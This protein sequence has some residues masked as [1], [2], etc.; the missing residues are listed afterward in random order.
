[1]RNRFEFDKD[2]IIIVGG[3][4]AGL[5]AAGTAASLG[6]KVV[7]LEKH[8]TNGKKLLIAGKGRCNITN[9]CDD[10]ETLIAN[11]PGNGSFLYSSF[12]TFSNQSI[13][14]FFE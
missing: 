2:S 13:I 3:G 10:V 12:Y 7:V 8:A 1:M 6:K 11:T 4:A 14:D 9:A 5:M